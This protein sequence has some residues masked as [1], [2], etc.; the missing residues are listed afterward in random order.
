MKG[1]KTSWTAVITIPSCKICPSYHILVETPKQYGRQK[2]MKGI[3]LMA[4]Y[5]DFYFEVTINN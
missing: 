4:C 2:K 1:L 3:F 5:I